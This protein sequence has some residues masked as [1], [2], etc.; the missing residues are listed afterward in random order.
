MEIWT[1]NNYNIDRM[2]I[3]LISFCT[4]LHTD[5]S[6]YNV[7]TATGRVGSITK[8]WLLNVVQLCTYV[9]GYSHQES[10]EAVFNFRNHFCY[11]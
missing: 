4:Y 11:L 9:W 2:V 6:M 3:I 5:V 8:N 1:F 7:V 10:A